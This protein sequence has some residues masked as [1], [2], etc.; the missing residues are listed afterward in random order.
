MPL[1]KLMNLVIF[2]FC[3]TLVH[4]QTADRFVDFVIEKEKYRKYRWLDFMSRLLYKFK[5]IVLVNKLW[6]KLNPMKRLKLMQIRGVS[7][8]TIDYL[9]EEFYQSEIKPKLIL[10]LYELLLKHREQND[11]IIIISG[12]YAPYIS[13]FTEQH[14][15]NQYFATEI[16]FAD[17]KVTGLF[18]GK[19]CLFDQKVV[20][21]NQFVAENKLTFQKSIAYSD[22]ISDLPLLQWADEAFVVSKNKSQPFA[23]QFGF[24]EIIHN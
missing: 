8:G 21:L 22:S 13:L 10:P 17:Q 12:G 6:P 7:E 19:D 20:L 14:Q 1:H 3:E 15:L 23:K 18:E 24:K 16:A 4:F 5:I 9:A 2:D 11:F